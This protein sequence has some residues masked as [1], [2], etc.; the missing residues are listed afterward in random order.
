MITGV[1]DRL[2]FY[3]ASY[4]EQF[5]VAKSVSFS[6]LVAL[7]RSAV[8]LLTALEGEM[9]KHPDRLKEGKL[10]ERHTRH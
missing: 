3:T 5:T 9:E 4:F 2:V 8:D 6:T 1:L 7:R 10:Y